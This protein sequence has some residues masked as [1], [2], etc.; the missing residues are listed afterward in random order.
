MSYAQRM[1]HINPLNHNAQSTLTKLL[2]QQKKFTA[3]SSIIKGEAQK[4]LDRSLRL[5]AIATVGSKTESSLSIAQKAVILSPW[6]AENWCSL[7]YI[8]SHN[9]ENAS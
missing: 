4:D 7:A 9:Q 5:K 6:K 2:L 3:A 8:R 1:V